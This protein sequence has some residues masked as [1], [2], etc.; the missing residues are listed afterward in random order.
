MLFALPLLSRLAWGAAFLAL[1]FYLG[2]AYGCSAHKLASM[3]AEM[4]IRDRE[5]AQLA[6]SEAANG[7]IEDAIERRQRSQFKSASKTIGRCVITGEE[8]QALNIIRE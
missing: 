3:Q 6:S 4:R 7:A 1:L 2:D 8:A 5:L